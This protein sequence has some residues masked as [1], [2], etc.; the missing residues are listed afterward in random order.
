MLHPRDDRAELEFEVLVEQIGEVAV[1]CFAR[2]AAE[3]GEVSCSSIRIRCCSSRRRCRRADPSVQIMGPAGPCYC[4]DLALTAAEAIEGLVGTVAPI[5]PRSSMRRATS[6]RQV[7]GRE[8]TTSYLA[9]S[10]SPSHEVEH[11]T[12]CQGAHDGQ[13]PQG[14]RRVRDDDER[15]CEERGRLPAN[16]ENVWTTTRL[17]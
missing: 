10:S 13:W 16:E 9:K 5:E 6:P 14:A 1:R 4:E 12:Y 7:I 2:S 3:V 11:E 15:A 8:D 17:A